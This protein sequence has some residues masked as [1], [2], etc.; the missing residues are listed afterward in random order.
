MLIFA[1]YFLNMK[2]LVQFLATGFFLVFAFNL[3]SQDAS[4]L[5]SF[6]N[7]NDIAIR[8]VQ[9]HGIN[10]TDVAAETTI[11]ELLM[12]QIASV[13]S[14]ETDPKKSADLAF[15]IRKKCTDFLKTNSKTSLEYL[16]FTE[17]E[18]K[19]F[20]SPQPINEADTY[21]SN[22]ENQKVKTLN[23]KDPHLFDNL[24]TRLK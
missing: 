13:A 14:F 2:K 22:T 6:I 18:R 9:K 7:E 17:K 10:L 8:S 20:Q 24:E 23:T 15:A 19:F 12:L 1:F 5:K 21:L 4:I 11:K 16:I 3:K